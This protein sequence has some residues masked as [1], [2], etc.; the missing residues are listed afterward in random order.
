[1][2]LRSKL[3][4][5]I[6]RIFLQLLKKNHLKPN[7]IRIIFCIFLNIT[8]TFIQT[9]TNKDKFNYYLLPYHIRDLQMT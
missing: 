5:I 2:C 7:G 8:W 4:C 1:M 6:V 9:N 3:I